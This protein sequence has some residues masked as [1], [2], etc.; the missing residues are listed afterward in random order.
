[1]KRRLVAAAL[2]LALCLV[3]IGCA[4]QPE[5]QE[6]VEPPAVEQQEQSAEEQQETELR[7]PEYL[8]IASLPKA[9]ALEQEY[10]SDGRSIL[11][12]QLPENLPEQLACQLLIFDITG[13]FDAM[14]QLVL[15]GSEGLEISVQNQEEQFSEGLFVESY[16]I[17]SVRALSYEQAYEVA[18]SPLSAGGELAEKRGITEWVLVDMYL[19]LKYSPEL[20]EQ[21]PPQLGDG[22]Y[23]Y[24]ML[25]GSTAEHPELGIAEVYWGAITQ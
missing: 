14:A 23:Q 12:E 9:E 19:D 4:G 5:L 7:Q 18:L 2:V 22:R 21:R 11:L 20:L 3:A 13:D 25:V 15:P 24:C 6:P 8:E 1:M 17:H 16:T 10:S